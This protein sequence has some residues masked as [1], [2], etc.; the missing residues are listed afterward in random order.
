MGTVLRSVLLLVLGASLAV[1]YGEGPP[2]AH[3]QSVTKV[4]GAEV[5]DWR[6]QRIS[7]EGLGY[8][9]ELVGTWAPEYFWKTEHE[10]MGKAC[11]VALG[12]RLPYPNPISV[13]VLTLIVYGSTSLQIEVV[14]ADG[15]TIASSAFL[16]IDRGAYLFKAEPSVWRENSP[17]FRLRCASGEV[18]EIQVPRSVI[19][20]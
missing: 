6:T 12:D 11:P 17:V 5:S 10:E 15:H 14:G 9:A 2:S 1:S 8:R 4:E 19:V 16:G 7:V 3:G 20:K 13:L 18:Q